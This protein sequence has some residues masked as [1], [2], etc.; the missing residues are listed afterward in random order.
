[1]N[2]REPHGGE[3][4]GDTAAVD[5]E[6]WR[7]HGVSGEKLAEKVSSISLCIVGA[8]ISKQRHGC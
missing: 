4:G 7:A 6:P 3:D 2:Y 1:M 5:E 8:K